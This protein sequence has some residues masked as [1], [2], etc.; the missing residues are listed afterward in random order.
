MLKRVCHC[1]TVNGC[2]RVKHQVNGDCTWMLVK[3]YG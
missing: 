2:I 3:G 1:L